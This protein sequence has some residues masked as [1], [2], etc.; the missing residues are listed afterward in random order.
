MRGFLTLKYVVFAVLICLLIS[1]GKA[2]ANSCDL[3]ILP[4][5]EFEG[6][7]TD[8]RVT[9]Y[10]TTTKKIFN[11]SLVDESPAFVNLAEGKYK[12]TV[13]KTGYKKSVYVY[14]HKCESNVSWL[15]MPVYKGSSKQ[16]VKVKE[17]DTFPPI[18]KGVTTVI[19]S[20]PDS[21]S[22]KVSDNDTKKSVPKV[23]YGGVLNGRAVSLPKPVY[24]SPDLN[25]SDTVV[26]Q[27][28]ID[29]E[30]KVES[31]IAVSGHPLLRAAAV[32]AAVEAKFSP[33][34]LSAVP[35]KVTGTLNYNFV[36][37]KKSLFE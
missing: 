4:Y 15:S 8:T 19:G 11:A 10:N 5:E 6:D 22:K 1:A 28:T 20:V 34:L 24:P 21:P 18:R 2:K 35:V 12:I 33:T 30:G 7:V 16:I 23:I 13:T 36:A 37:P 9:A 17:E 31:A 29:E 26:V 32:K 25:I 14:Q 3:G 27:V